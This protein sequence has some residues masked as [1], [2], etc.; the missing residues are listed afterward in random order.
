MHHN[1]GAAVSVDA[2]RNDHLLVG[3]LLTKSIR[4]TS[5][6]IFEIQSGNQ[7]VVMNVCDLLKNVQERSPTV[8]IIMLIAIIA[9]T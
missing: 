7:I 8:V 3:K 6:F 5:L 2:I 1:C 9:K 4:C